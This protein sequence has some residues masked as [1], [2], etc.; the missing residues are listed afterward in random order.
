MLLAERSERY[1]YDAARR[2]SLR[3]TN[4]FAL[5]KRESSQSFVSDM[6]LGMSMDV[7][8]LAIYGLLA[9]CGPP[10]LFVAFLLRP[11]N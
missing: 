8:E 1:R 4:S 3:R 7:M 11:V 2:A 5:N 10:L 9:V 6:S